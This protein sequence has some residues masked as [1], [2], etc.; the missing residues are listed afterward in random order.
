MT[1]YPEPIGYLDIH[2]QSSAA[3]SSSDG[4]G[5]RTHRLEPPRAQETTSRRFYE[6]FQQDMSPA[7]NSLTR[8]ENGKFQIDIHVYSLIV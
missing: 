3:G 1:S 5:R 7:P 6:N 2:H 4:A 8:Y